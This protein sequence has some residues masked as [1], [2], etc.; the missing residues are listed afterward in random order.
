MA[1]VAART[2]Q[3]VVSCRADSVDIQLIIGILDQLANG[4]EIPLC[5]SYTKRVVTRCVRAAASGSAGASL[6]AH[7]DRVSTGWLRV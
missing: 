4:V 3:C 1:A 5:G 6:V 7:F 2:R